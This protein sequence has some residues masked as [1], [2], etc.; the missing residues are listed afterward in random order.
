MLAMPATDGGLDGHAIARFQ[1]RDARSDDGY[2]ARWFMTQDLRIRRRIAID[3]A[4]R[5]PMHVA[6]TDPDRAE[7]EQNL[8][9][10]GIGS[11]RSFHNFES[12]RRYQL[13]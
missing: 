9:G 3:I 6:A 8:S 13:S 1:G 5:I 10:A 11:E 4:V 7:L 2:F 12:V